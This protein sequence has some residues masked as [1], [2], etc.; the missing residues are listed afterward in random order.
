[1]KVGKWYTK[2]LQDENDMYKGIKEGLAALG[3][4]LAPIATQGPQSFDHHKD[5]P[6]IQEAQESSISDF[7]S[8]PID[9]FLW[10]IMQVE[11][12][13]GKNT[14]HRRMASGMHKGHKAAGRWGLMP[15]SVN[16]MLN[17]MQNS[18]DSNPALEQMRGMNSQELDSHFKDNPKH[19]LGI[20]RY[21][22]NHAMERQGNDT[23]RAAYSW[24]MGHNKSY[25]QH[26]DYHIDNHY[27]VKRYNNYDKENPYSEMYESS[28]SGFEPIDMTMKSEPN[29]LSSQIK[30]WLKLRDAKR[31]KG[32]NSYFNGAPDPGRQREEELD[33]QPKTLEELINLEMKGRD[34]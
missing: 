31:Q 27:Y 6:A 4:A 8:E 28:K 24:L 19:E 3:I 25:A 14:N 29:K 21:M 2:R 11:S 15:H 30:Q 18:G 1:M 5:R 17:R 26:P 33:N 13:G 10:N 16:E 9:R 23:N 12:S 20:A 22:A 34:A 7:G 32:E